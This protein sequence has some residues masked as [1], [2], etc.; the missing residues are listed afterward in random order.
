MR[1]ITNMIYFI[2]QRTIK[3]M[4]TQ[5]KEEGVELNV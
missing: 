4:I 2:M 3:K 5:E 1:K